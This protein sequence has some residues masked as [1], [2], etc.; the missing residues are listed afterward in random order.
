[1]PA[2]GYGGHVRFE[3]VRFES[4]QIL[5]CSNGKTYVGHICNIEERF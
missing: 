4:V 2:A 1:M 3:N 5:M